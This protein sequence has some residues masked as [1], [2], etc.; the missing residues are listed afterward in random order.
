MNINDLKHVTGIGDKLSEKILDSVGGE[1]NLA[2]IV[3]DKDLEKLSSIDGISQRKA[4]KIMNALLG[5]PQEKF[6]KN[7]R[8]R[9]LYDD[10]ISKILDF[11]STSYSRNRVRLLAPSTDVDV[12]SSHLDF[13]MESKS[14]VDSLPLDDVRFYMKRL[15]SPLSPNSSYDSSKLIIVESYEDREYLVDLGLNKYFSIS[16]ID[17]S[18]SFQEEISGYELVYYVYREGFVDFGDMSNLLMVSID[19]PLY[20]IAPDLVIDYFKVN[21][22]LY[23]NLF[24]VRSL[25]G[26]DSVCGDI[27]D[28]LSSLS[29]EDE[30]YDA[31]I[32][33][34]VLNIKDDMDEELKNTIKNI[35]IAGDEVLHLLNNNFPPKLEEIF[36]TIMSKGNEK[37]K[38]KTKIN[39]DPYI[40]KYP[41]EIDDTEIKRAEEEQNK[42]KENTT[43][44]KKTKIAQQLSQIKETVEKELKETIK[45]DYKITL[46]TFAKKYQLNKPKITE[47]IKIT[48][49]IHL[50]LAL[51]KNTQKITYQLT[52]KENIALLTGANSGGKTTLLETLG[53]ISIMA[54]MGLPVP[55]EEAEVKILDEIYYFTKQRS[56]DAGAFETFLNTFIPITTTKTEKLVLLDELEGITELDASVK[57]ISSFI[58][59]LKKTESYGIIVTHMA[60]ELS[61]YI[62]IR[63]DGIEAKGLDENYNLIVDRTPKMNT[64]AR[65]TPELILK[66]IY[67]NSD[68]KLKEIYGEILKKF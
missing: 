37:L 67:E 58:E 45:L 9:L 65:S 15:S 10:I 59:M 63:I 16:V 4:I 24:S 50:D 14:F 66:R 61:R 43:H 7:E 31:D 28:L 17:N 55:A 21:E 26:L 13:V 8:A 48:N 11:S 52:P 34:I 60:K 12:I 38:E 49:A 5:N 39:F 62:E 25:L 30:F 36:N 53:Q 2:E 33:D 29:V 32:R 47:N 23:S 22:S 64:L 27:G 68:G 20:E 40:K 56:L 57:I 35:D 42:I 46:G 18:L 51:K 1:E 54:Q 41:I 6:L 3:E 19:S 44:D